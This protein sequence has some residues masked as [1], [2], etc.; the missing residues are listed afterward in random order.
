MGKG[1]SINDIQL[2]HFQLWNNYIKYIIAL[3]TGT[4]MDGSLP[5]CHLWMAPHQDIDCMTCN[6]WDFHLFSYWL[7]QLHLLQC[8]SSWQSCHFYGRTLIPQFFGGMAGYSLMAWPQITLSC[9]LPTLR[10]GSGAP[11]RGEKPPKWGNFYQPWKFV[12][13]WIFWFFCLDSLILT[14]IHHTSKAKLYNWYLGGDRAVSFR[15]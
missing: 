15:A 12:R 11:F 4:Y 3:Q 1:L 5:R 8:T 2:E 14:H 13:A 9:P 6:A 7:P 10:G